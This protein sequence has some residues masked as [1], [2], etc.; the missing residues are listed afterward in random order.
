MH[1]PNVVYACPCG[2]SS[3]RNVDVSDNMFVCVCKHKYLYICTYACTDTYI[4]M[5]IQ[6]CTHIYIHIYIHVHVDMYI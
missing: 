4:C 6:I 2:K 1:T 5:Y 3:Y